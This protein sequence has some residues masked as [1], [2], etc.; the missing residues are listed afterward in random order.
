MRKHLSDKEKRMIKDLRSGGWKIR[1]L[2]KY[3]RIS[4]N[5]VLKYQRGE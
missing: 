2:M 5:S 1:E 4:K 3:F